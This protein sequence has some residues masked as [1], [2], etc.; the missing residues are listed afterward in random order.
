M[1]WSSAEGHQ[2]VLM[3]NC[4]D[5]FPWLWKLLY[6]PL[7]CCSR[8]KH[9]LFCGRQEIPYITNWNKQIS[10]SSQLS[11]IFRQVYRF[12]VKLFLSITG[13]KPERIE[14]TLWGS[15]CR[16]S[17]KGCSELTWIEAFFCGHSEVIRWLKV[18]L[19]QRYISYLPKGI[20]HM[21]RKAL[22]LLDVSLWK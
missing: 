12:S 2:H 4:N 21:L 8:E 7:K 14:W 9:W 10:S 20:S 16:T 1:R 19:K 6:F 11:G 22:Y 13:A 15:T 18:S 3:L 5:D 17:P